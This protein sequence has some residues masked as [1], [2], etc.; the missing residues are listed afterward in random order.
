MS[1]PKFESARLAYRG[2]RK[3]DLDQMYEM[4]SDPEV[5][6]GA[7][8]DGAFP[9]S[10]AFKEKMAGWTNC[11]LFSIVLE[12]D[13]DKWVGIA[14][15]RVELPKDRE[16][17]AAITL[18]REFWGKGYGTEAT[19]W[20]VDQAFKTLNL[21]RVSLGVFGSNPRALA[22]YKKSGFVEEGRKRKGTFVQ[23]KWEDLILMGI[24]DEEYWA[25]QE[26]K[27]GVSEGKAPIA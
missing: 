23:G 27:N 4:F 17:E 11:A 19:R 14:S 26:E 10:D 5:Q 21:H 20:L 7:M 25:G 3:S 24:L 6:L 22:T 13:T 15:L 8:I 12:K 18:R 9:R 1:V 16:G 2:F